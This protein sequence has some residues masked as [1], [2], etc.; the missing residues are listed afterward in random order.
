MKKILLI[1]GLLYLTGCS[2]SNLD[3]VK[4][5]GEKRWLELGYQPVGYEGYEWGIL[6]FGTNYGGANV[7]WRVKNIPDNGVTYTGYLKRWGDEIHVY[8]PRAIDAIKP[9]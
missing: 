3:Y 4:E 1:V 7:W 8:G 6:G 2:Y 9:N 5:H